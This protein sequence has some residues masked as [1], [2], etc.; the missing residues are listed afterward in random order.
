MNVATTGGRGRVLAKGTSPPTR[1]FQTAQPPG[2]RA[3]ARKGHF[4]FHPVRV[5]H[6]TKK[7]K[8]NKQRQLLALAE[9]HQ[10]RKIALLTAILKSA[11]E[12]PARKV[13]LKDPEAF[14]GINPTRRVG[15][16]RQHKCYGNFNDVLKFIKQ[17]L[18]SCYNFSCPRANFLGHLRPKKSCKLWKLWA[19]LSGT[20]A[21]APRFPRSPLFLERLG[22]IKTQGRARA[23]G[24]EWC[25]ALAETL[26]CRLPWPG[27]RV[28]SATARLRFACRNS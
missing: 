10:K 14:P 17:N 7:A 3:Y 18:T 22:H 24:R 8:N 9:H 5:T 6:Q 1:C 27:R 2:A 26:H 28:P 4:P 23:R 20:F 11:Q 21:D 13:I 15:R 16:P 12:D 19:Q 25:P